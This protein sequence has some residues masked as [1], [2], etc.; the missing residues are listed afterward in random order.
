LA[1]R[2]IPQKPHANHAQHGNPARLWQSVTSTQQPLLEALDVL[3]NRA[4]WRD[5][6]SALLL[7]PVIGVVKKVGGWWLGVTRRQ[8]RARWV[9]GRVSGWVGG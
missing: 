7:M 2:K 9:G 1:L 8:M 5:S 4:S 6:I 3:V